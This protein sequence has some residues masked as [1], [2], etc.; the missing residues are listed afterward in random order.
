MFRL[1]DLVLISVLFGSMLG[2]ILLPGFG[3]FFQPYPMVLLMFLLFLSLLSVRIDAIRHTVRESLLRILLLTLIKMVILP[4]AIY[5]LFRAVYPSYAIAALLLSG[6]STG[7]LAPFIS[8]LLKGN[9]ALALVMVVITSP[10]LPFT[11]PV[12]VKLLVS[13]SIEI[14][15]LAMVRMLFMVIFVPIFL[16]ELLRRL[17]PALLKRM[18]SVQFPAS[19][20][21]IALINLGVFSRYA[22]FFHQKPSTILI[23]IFVAIFLCAAFLMVALSIQWKQPLENQMA[24]VASLGNVN[25]ILVIVFSAQFF[26]PPEPTVAAMYQIP[27]FGLILPMRIYRRWQEGK[28]MAVRGG[29]SGG[30]KGGV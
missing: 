20:F 9:N 6:V 1:K 28:A 11:L 4:I 19:L 27:F 22:D 24:A 5:S 3:S 21:A 14:S 10:L 18:M 12:L 13:R 23:S 30:L 7:V 17:W 16:V 25:N 15:L 8:N 29:A 26:G 2:G